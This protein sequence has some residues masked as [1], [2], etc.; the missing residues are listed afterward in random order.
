MAN[1][2]NREPVEKMRNVLRA[3]PLFVAD[4]PIDDT[5]DEFVC[6]TLWLR[7]RL[8]VALR[9]VAHRGLVGK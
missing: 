3:P 4:E 5:H 2:E 9:E 8:G 1:P 6:A 7:V